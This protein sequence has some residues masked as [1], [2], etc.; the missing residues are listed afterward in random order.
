MNGFS[1]HWFGDLFKEQR[2]GDFKGSFLRSFSL[3]L[4]VMILTVVISL[5]AV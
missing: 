1:F 5:A 3:A 2:V 4:L